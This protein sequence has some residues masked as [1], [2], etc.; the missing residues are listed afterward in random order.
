MINHSA[1]DVDDFT[2]HLCDLGIVGN[3]YDGLMEIP[4]E[5]IQQ[6]QDGLTADVIQGSGGF[7]AQQ[8]QGVLGDRPGNGDALLFTAGKLGR[9]N[10]WP[11]RS[12]RLWPE[13][14]WD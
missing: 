12:N 8:Q 1:F 10:Y 14:L 13:S 7:I 6:V 11:D 5:F 3:Q 4:V 2:G 9:G